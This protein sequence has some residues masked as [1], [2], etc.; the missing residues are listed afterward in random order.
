MKLK[1]IQK[2]NCVI[3][4]TDSVRLRKFLVDRNIS[5]LGGVDEDDKFLCF[6]ATSRP[7]TLDS[8][9]ESQAEWPIYHHFDIEPEIE[10]EAV[11]EEP[12]IQKDS[13]VVVL[14][15]NFVAILSVYLSKLFMEVHPLNTTQK[16]ILMITCTLIVVVIAI[17]DIDHFDMLRKVNGKK[18]INND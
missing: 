12:V 10:A 2:T 16:S 18:V 11:K 8:L 6:F 15:C 9:L 7:V 13:D 14:F 3:Q 1:D 17:I 4:F 5:V